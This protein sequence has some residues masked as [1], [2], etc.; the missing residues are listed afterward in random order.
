MSM[1]PGSGSPDRNIQESGS[2]SE[3]SRSYMHGSIVVIFSSFYCFFQK[4]WIKFS[5]SP[6]DWLVFHLD[7]EEAFFLFKLHISIVYLSSFLL[8]VYCNSLD[9]GHTI[10]WSVNQNCVNERDEEEKILK[11]RY[12]AGLIQDIPHDLWVDQPFGPRQFFLIFF[13]LE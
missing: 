9:F 3:N 5:S 13:Y 11:W 6:L 12:K 10:D 2:R 1:C 4:V 7:W 8:S